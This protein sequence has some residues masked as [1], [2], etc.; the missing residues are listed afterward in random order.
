MSAVSWLATELPIAGCYL[1]W[2]SDHIEPIYP[3]ATQVMIMTHSISFRSPLLILALNIVYCWISAIYET[4]LSTLGWPLSLTTYAW[5]LGLGNLCLASLNGFPPN[6]ADRMTIHPQGGLLM[7]HGSN[8]NHP[9]YLAIW[10]SSIHHLLCECV[11][12]QRQACVFSL[13]S[14]CGTRHRESL[15]ALFYSPQLSSPSFFF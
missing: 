12:S 2:G 11:L 8:V 13:I 3:G 14:W 5:Q 4:R 6:E 9:S 15:P 10:Q 7:C 1:L